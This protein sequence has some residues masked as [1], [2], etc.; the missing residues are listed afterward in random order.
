[1]PSYTDFDPV[2]YVRQQPVNTLLRDLP[3][4]SAQLAQVFPN[5]ARERGL[6][7]SSVDVALLSVGECAREE[8]KYKEELR[9]RVHQRGISMSTL[10]VSEHAFLRPRCFPASTDVPT[11]AGSL[12]GA[13]FMCWPTVTNRELE[14][15]RPQHVSPVMVVSWDLSHMTLSGSA[16][17]APAWRE[18]NALGSTT[19]NILQFTPSYSRR[20]AETDRRHDQQ[21]QLEPHSISEI[22]EALYTLMSIRRRVYPFELGCESLFFFL[23]KMN[24]LQGVST[25]KRSWARHL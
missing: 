25:D 1:M 15:V 2:A 14:A 24:F 7:I 8:G 3:L 6:D 17:P 21:D 20:S 9:S 16:I 11:N 5:L 18:A 23:L 12:H 22:R 10:K 4:T 19:I 13:R